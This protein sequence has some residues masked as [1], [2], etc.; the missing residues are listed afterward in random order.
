MTKPL[1]GIGADIRDSGSGGREQAYGFTTYVDAVIRAGAIPLLIPPQSENIVELLA[2]LDG[3]LLSG[4]RDCDPAIYG[5]ECHA[6]IKPMDIRRQANDLE[7]ARH[8]REQ[9]VPTLGVCLGVQIMAIAAGGSLI[10]D[11]GSEIDTKIR[12]ES[13]PEGRRHHPVRIESGTILASILEESDLIVNSSH[14]QAVRTAGEGLR[15]TARAPDGIVEAIEDANH[16]FY[17][18]L[19]WHP[20]DM[21]AEDSAARI[22]DAFIAAARRRALG[23]EMSPVSS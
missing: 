14:H 8:S 17:V 19:Q 12:H 2:S 11:I 1:I 21:S 15:V 4:G 16:P 20:E 9:G 10:Q 7:L 22:F 6:S 13:E 3:V 18:G 5:E 23:R